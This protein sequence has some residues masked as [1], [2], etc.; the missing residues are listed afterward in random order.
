[1][2]GGCFSTVLAQSIVLNSTVLIFL[3][4]AW[5]PCLYPVAIVRLEIAPAFQNVSGWAPSMRIPHMILGVAS[6]LKRL[7]CSNSCNLTFPGHVYFAFVLFA[8]SYTSTGRC[9][10]SSRGKMAST[11][12]RRQVEALR[13]SSTGTSSDYLQRKK[14]K[15][16][17]LLSPD[18][19]RSLIPPNIRVVEGLPSDKEIS[20]DALHAPEQQIAEP[21]K[22]IFGTP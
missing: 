8:W 3:M 2:S 4:R 1:M 5:Y 10:T 13:H 21:P 18:Q 9:L 16:S 17:L 6:V 19:V 14:G 11:S 22:T 15:A 12:L 20:T 7:S